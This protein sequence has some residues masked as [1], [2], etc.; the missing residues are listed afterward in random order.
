VSTTRSVDFTLN[1]GLLYY[2]EGHRSECDR[3]GKYLSNPSNLAHHKKKVHGILSKDKPSHA[4]RVARTLQE[5]HKAQ[6]KAV[7]LEVTEAG[8]S[9][10]KE[11]VPEVDMFGPT[12]FNFTVGYQPDSTPGAGGS[13]LRTAS[14]A[15]E[16]D[17]SVLDDLY[18]DVDTDTSSNGDSD[19]T[20]SQPSRELLLARRLLTAVSIRNTSGE[21]YI[22]SLQFGNSLTVPSSC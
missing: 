18:V 21:S 1:D 15:I 14:N 12:P 9:E 3:C 4:R 16:V 20:A 7:P 19:S 6:T 2:C 11:F 22:P 8:A 13:G 17:E 5:S 10:E